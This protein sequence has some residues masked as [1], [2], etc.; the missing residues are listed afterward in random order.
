MFANVPNIPKYHQ[1]L[2]IRAAIK[3]FYGLAQ[4]FTE[5]TRQQAI[6][7]CINWVIWQVPRFLELRNKKQK[8]FLLHNPSITLETLAE[9]EVQL[10]KHIQM[11]SDSTPIFKQMCEAYL[12]IFEH[13]FYLL[14]EIYWEMAKERSG[15]VQNGREYSDIDIYKQMVDEQMVDEQMAK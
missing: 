11:L 2:K 12:E 6:K 13:P 3:K 15:V 7:Y 9:S 1:L 5:Q 10:K 4:L 8:L 14:E